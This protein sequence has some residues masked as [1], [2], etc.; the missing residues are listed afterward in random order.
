ME[1]V[2]TLIVGAGVSGLAAAAALKGRDFLL[3]EA[4]GE[5]GGYCKTVQRD[6]FT[7]DY[8]GHFFHFKNPEVEAWLRARM[9]GQRVRTVQKRSFI[10]YAGQW[11]DFPFQKNIHQLP[12]DEF[13][14]CL[15]DLYLARA[16]GTPPAPERNF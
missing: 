7:W 5:V 2:E 15:S 12:K 14:E 4:S 6:G 16:P 8:S 11:L 10:S 1:R 3:L 9:P 13:I